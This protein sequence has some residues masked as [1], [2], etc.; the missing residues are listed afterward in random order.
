LNSSQG[1]NRPVPAQQRDLQEDCVPGSSPSFDERLEA[2]LRR[3]GLLVFLALAVVGLVLAWRCRF[4][5]D[6]AFISF[7]YA[8]NLVEGRGLTWSGAR[9]EGYTNPLWVLWIALGL[10][11][12]VDAI[13][14]SWLGGMISF[15]ATLIATWRLALRLLD[16]ALPALLAVA[17]LVV[18]YSVLAYAT[19]GLE[20]MAQTAL[21]AWAAVA[22]EDLRRGAPRTVRNAATLSLLL[23]AAVMTRPDSALPG[24]ALAAWAAFAMLRRHD[25][26]RVWLALVLPAAL[27][28]GAWLG[29]KLAYYGRLLPNTFYAKTGV[30]AAMTANGAAYIGRFLHWYRLWPVF[31]VG[32]VALAARRRDLDAR[33][34]APLAVVVSWL[35]YIV[36]VGGDFMEF[37]LLVPITPFLFLLLAHLVCAQVAPLLRGQAVVIALVV[38]ALLAW[39][40]VHHARTFRTQTADQALDSIPA[41]ADFYKVYP[42]GD[43]S[44]IGRALRRELANTDPLVALDAVG[45]VPWYSGLRTVDQLGLNDAF[46]A[47]HGLRAD[48]SYR[49]PGHQRHASLTYLR[50]RGVNFVIGHPTLVPLDVFAVAG[51][52]P[53]WWQM[54]D[55]WVYRT[56]PLNPGPIGPVRLVLVPVR[57]GQGLLAWYLTPTPALDAAIVRGGWPVW[58]FVAGAR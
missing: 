42:D 58:D 46:V 11:C 49:R 3:R 8:R 27:V 50:E 37:R 14:W 47:E 38:I 54:A 41:L 16:R 48:A 35:A 53:K 26:R 20:T 2:A 57:P 9:I 7:V 24:L 51:N 5:Q 52:D 22:A 33:L 34:L 17:L 12:G 23:A 40:S 29:W 10:R 18:N 44:V 6:D 45:A 25:A 32:L 4:I 56:T 15:A 21:L 1:R 19:G 31:A 36:L 13:A 39:G 28:L 43:W 30:T 55:D